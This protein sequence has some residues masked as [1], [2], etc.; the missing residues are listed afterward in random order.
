MS[1][2]DFSFSMAARLKQLREERGLSHQKLSDTIEE[3][4]GIS[5]SKDSLMKYEVATEHHT[6]PFKNLG[7]RVEYLTALATFYNVSTDY[8]LG[9]TDTKSRSA[10]VQAA[11]QITGLNEA[12]IYDLL[13]FAGSLGEGSFSFREHY[14]VLAD[15][16]FE[17]VNEFIAFALNNNERYG[18]P[19]DRY[20][21]FRQQTDAHNKAQAAWEEM[22]WDE[23]EHRSAQRMATFTDSSIEDSGF[24]PL[25]AADAADFFRTDFC[26]GFKNY[27]KEKHPLKSVL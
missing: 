26:D 16:A 27:L 17:M 12:S 10:D 18:F 24:Y 21:A 22:N 1:R 4:L 19:F 11:C 20:L 15:Y 9:L 13:S 5:I 23:R 6:T 3:M 2:K 25:L 8:I 7:M 14:G